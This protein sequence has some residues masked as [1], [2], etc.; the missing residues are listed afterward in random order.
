MAEAEVY[1]SVWIGKQ[2]IS[3][4]DTKIKDKTVMFKKVGGIPP[5]N[6]FVPVLANTEELPYQERTLW[7][8]GVGDTNL[9]VR[10]YFADLRLDK[11]YAVINPQDLNTIMHL[12]NENESL[13]QEIERL[14]QMMFDLSNEDRWK[15][16]IKKEMDNYNAIKGYGY[17]GGS[18]YG[19]FNTAPFGGGMLPSLEGGEPQQF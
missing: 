8:P 2:Y 1:K 4:G 17:G 12:K 14:F 6:S 3:I 16:R 11:Y 7:S 9:K 19:G 15:K 5:F 13:H 10:V 18:A